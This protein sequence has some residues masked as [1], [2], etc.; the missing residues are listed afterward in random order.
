MKKNLF[1]EKLGEE[2]FGLSGGDIATIVSP[3][4]HTALDVQEE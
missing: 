1:L 2:A 3:H 4:K